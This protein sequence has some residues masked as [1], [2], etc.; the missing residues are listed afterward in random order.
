M[1]IVGYILDMLGDQSLLKSGC[2]KFN[3]QWLQMGMVVKSIQT[4]NRWHV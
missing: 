4:G 3:E 2:G 1:D